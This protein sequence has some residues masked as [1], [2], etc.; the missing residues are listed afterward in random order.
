MR[1]TGFESLVAA[2][3]RDG[4]RQFAANCERLRLVVI[5][6][7]MPE[8]DG[9]EVLAAMRKIATVPTIVVTGFEPQRIETRLA[10]E[11]ARSVAFLGKPFGVPQLRQ[12]VASLLSPTD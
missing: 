7:S 8:M 12:A 11:L 3:G 9:L 5:D 6:Y 2:D 1:S 4:I 10:P